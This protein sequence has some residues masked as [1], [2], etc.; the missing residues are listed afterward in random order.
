MLLTSRYFTVSLLLHVILL[1]ILNFFC[2][3]KRIHKKIIVYGAHSKNISKAI[4]KPYRTVIPFSDP[5]GKQLGRSGKSGSIGRKKNTAQKAITKKPARRAKR[6]PKKPAPA[7]KIAPVVTQK[8]APAVEKKQTLQKKAIPEPKVATKKT[9]PLPKKKI[10]ETP[11]VKPPQ[12]VIEEKKLPPIPPVEIVPPVETIS[13]P[14]PTAIPELTPVPEEFSAQVETAPISTLNETDVLPQSESPDEAEAAYDLITEESAE[15]SA[16]Q[17]YISKEIARVWHPSVGIPR[18]TEAEVEFKIDNH[19]NLVS[20]K[21]KN[22][23]KVIIYDRSIVMAIAEMKFIPL[24]H[25]KVF[26]VKFKQ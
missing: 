7:R 20:S 8:P 24:C 10:A 6:Q 18:D 22:K 26:G 5:H 9:I 25:N 4:Y 21:F 23:S 2:A 14:A 16:L 12:K 19:G 17:D 15:W 3:E 13:E 11:T 1:V